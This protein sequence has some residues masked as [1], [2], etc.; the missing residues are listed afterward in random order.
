MSKI[1]LPYSAE[2]RLCSYYLLSSLITAYSELI[3]YVQS[4]MPMTNIPVQ[5]TRICTYGT[6]LVLSSYKKV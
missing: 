1:K 5:Y 6:I 4:I 2:I 3:Q